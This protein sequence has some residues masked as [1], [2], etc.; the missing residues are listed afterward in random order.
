[1]SNNREDF[2]P[3]IRNSAWWASDTRRA[4]NNKAV[5][6][7]LEKQGKL[8]IPDLSGIEAVQMG[9]VMQPIIGQLAQSRLGIEL[10]E[11]DY[12]LTHPK[13]NWFRSHFDFI[14]ADGTVLV[15][16]KNYNANTRNKFDAENNRIPD[17]DYAQLLHECAVHGVDRAYLAVL[18]GGQEFV[19][20]EFTFTEEQK[21]ELIQSMAKYW[22]YV[23]TGD[24]PQAQTLEQTKLLYPKDNSNIILANQGIENGIG[25]LKR[26]K[27]DIKALEEQEERLETELRNIMKDAA[28]VRSIDGTTLVTWKSSKSS[29]RFSA[30]LLKSAMPDIYQQFVVEQPGSRRFLI[31]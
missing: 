25:M 28:E 5:E 15:E 20:F 12:P 18:F 30:D 1:M 27:A 21:N 19:T 3:D 26:I 14:S 24:V 6:V 9:H 17:A 2:A 22:A 31:K 11:A 4:M 16:A 29:M 13:H 8:D 10:K 23:Q 7:I